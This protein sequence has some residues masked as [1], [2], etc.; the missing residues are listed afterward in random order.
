MS[1]HDRFKEYAAKFEEVYLSE[2]WDELE[3][4]FQEDAVY[5]SL[6]EAPFGQRFEGRAA[7]IAGARG[8]LGRFDRRFDERSVDMTEGPRVFTDKVWFEWLAFYCIE[9]APDFTFTGEK[10]LLF[11]DDKITSIEVRIKPETVNR[12]HQYMK[13][14][15]GQLHPAH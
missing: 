1:T 3:E 7:V 14:Y 9:G 13:K 10:T 8:M 2:K 5:E 12:Y 4:F 11:K 6:A 15:E